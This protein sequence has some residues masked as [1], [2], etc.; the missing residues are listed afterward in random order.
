LRKEITWFDGKC[1]KLVD[2]RK[3]AKLYWLQDSNVMD[4]DNLNNVRHE[5]SRYFRNK[6]KE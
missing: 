5:I 6:K 2:Q 3:Y 1:T 4:G